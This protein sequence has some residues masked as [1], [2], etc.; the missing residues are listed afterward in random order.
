MAW[1]FSQ[2]KGKPVWSTLAVRRNLAGRGAIERL[3]NSF[4]YPSFLPDP[5]G[6]F[7]IAVIRSATWNNRNQNETE[8]LD[9]SAS[10]SGSDYDDEN[11]DEYEHV[12][13]IIPAD[14]ISQCAKVTLEAPIRHPSVYAVCGHILA[15]ACS[16]QILVFNLLTG[17]IVQR[18]ELPCGKVVDIALSSNWLVVISSG[19]PC[20]LPEEPCTNHFGF[21]FGLGKVDLGELSSVAQSLF[22]KKQQPIH[23]YGWAWREGHACRLEHAFGMRRTD[24][25]VCVAMEDAVIYYS[26]GPARVVQALCAA[27]DRSIWDCEVLGSQ[28]PPTANRVF[29]LRVH[30]NI[31]LAQLGNMHSGFCDVVMICGQTGIIAQRI[32]SCTAASWDT[33]LGITAS[34]VSEREVFEGFGTYQLKSDIQGLRVWP[35]GPT[36]LDQMPGDSSAWFREFGNLLRGNWLQGKP[37]FLAGLISHV[38]VGDEWVAG[39]P[40]SSKKQ[41]NMKLFGWTSTHIHQLSQHRL[42]NG[43]LCCLSAFPSRKMTHA[44]VQ[45][46]CYPLGESR[47]SV[48][49]KLG[50]FLRR[51][52]HHRNTKRCEQHKDV[53]HAT[54][55]DKERDA[56]A[57]SR[58]AAVDLGGLQDMPVV[59]DVQHVEAAAVIDPSEAKQVVHEQWATS[60]IE[61]VV[62][63]PAVRST[64]DIVVLALTKHSKEVEDVLLDS[65]IARA[66]VDKKV[67]IKPQWAGG[68][69]IFVSDFG[70]GD[71]ADFRACFGQ[72]IGLGPHHVVIDFRD[73]EV[74][75]KILKPSA[76]T[77]HLATVKTGG[78]LCIPAADHN[79]WMACSLPSSSISSAFEG[80]AMERGMEQ[81]SVSTEVEAIF[82]ENPQFNVTIKR[83]F[84]HVDISG[85]DA[86]LLRKSHS[87]PCMTN[88]VPE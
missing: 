77:R 31:V 29:D 44:S 50:L 76:K 42:P 88:C 75:L 48:W 19:L 56:V 12:A 47:L 6:S 79:S 86:S 57:V 20:D 26:V 54:A 17:N 18:L 68:A 53:Q 66:L 60:R 7:L 28:E 80:P 14:G 40:K 61:Q 58:V 1:N 45:R 4:L 72:R 3:V 71:A 9:D 46:S 59:Q 74:I 67:D 43:R 22:Q 36:L 65:S 24:E 78:R 87:E 41:K 33:R 32:Q 38:H 83:T 8:S 37:L 21:S 15:T 10:G 64:K 81:S 69:K 11:G 35:R 51:L 73:E 84:W 85:L 49:S 23:L 39:V 27:D 70:P 52:C 5:E 2:D 62:P 13:C 63:P 55:G 82:N 34:A 25:E 30:S 16:S